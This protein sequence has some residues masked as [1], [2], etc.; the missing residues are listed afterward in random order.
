[1]LILGFLGSPRVDGKCGR[2]L[3]RALEGAESMGAKTK[4]ALNYYK[5]SHLQTGVMDNNF[6]RTFDQWDNI[7]IITSYNFKQD[8]EEVVILP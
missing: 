7:N 2:L 1:M 6:N 4:S 3:K 5:S 8:A